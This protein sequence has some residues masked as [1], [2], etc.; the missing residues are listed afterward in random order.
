MRSFEKGIMDCF[1]PLRALHSEVL[2]GLEGREAV[3]LSLCQQAVLEL[4]Q[5]GPAMSSSASEWP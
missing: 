4:W 3:I 2:Q 5:R 1:L